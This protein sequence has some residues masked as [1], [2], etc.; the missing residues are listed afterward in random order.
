MA[1]TLAGTCSP[2]AMA[3]EKEGLAGRVRA[4][5]TQRGHCGGR[6]HRPAKMQAAR[7]AAPEVMR[8]ASLVCLGSFIQGLN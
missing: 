4:V 5:E 6:G 3:S 8:G 1:V 2:G 7:D